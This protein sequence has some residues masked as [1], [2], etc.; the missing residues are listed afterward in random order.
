[1]ELKDLLTLMWRNVIYIVLGLILGAG[2]G[3]IVSKYQAP[4]YE[5][6]TK[7]FV[8]RTRQQSSSD[9]LSLSD[10]QLLAINIQMAKSQPVLNE[11][12]AQLGSKIDV[13]NIQV[14][15]IPNTLILQIKVQDSDA[16]R[17]ATIA[18]LL[19]NT[20]VQQNETLLSGRYLE[21][22]N[23]INQQLDQ[24]QKQ[25]DDL[26]VRIT[27]TKTTSVQEQLTLVKQQIEELKNESTSLETD[28]ANYPHQYPTPLQVVLLSEKQLRLQQVYSMLTL[29][30]QI[31]T[32]LTYTGKPG[33]DSSNLDNPQITVLQSALDTYK[34]INIALINN[35][36]SIRLAR[37]QSSQNVTQIVSAAPPK[38]PVRPMP[39]VYLL[40]GSGVGLALAA[41]TI[42]IIDQLDDSL[43]SAGQI[44]ELLGLPILG[45]VFDHR[46]NKDKLITAFGAGSK[47]VDAMRVLGTNLEIAGIKK[48]IRTLLI[49]NADQS[50]ARTNIAANLAI[51]NAQLGKQVILLDGDLK[52]PH[53]HTLFGMENQK[54][55]AELL[56]GKVDI[57]NACHE[58][59]NVEGMTLIPSG[60]VEKDATGWLTSEKLT[61]LMS[62]LKKNADLVIVDCPATESADAQIL[63]SRM[64]AVL[65]VVRM[66]HTHIE[67]AQAM[68]KR[69]QLIGARLTGAVIARTIQ[70]RFDIPLQIKPV[71]TEKPAQIKNEIETPAVSLPQNS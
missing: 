33:Q 58:V 11:V 9:M 32:N 12:A 51:V 56:N 10:D 2:L 65:L 54:G 57:R 48:N 34:Q 27:Q 36:E 26:Q 3:T 35:R 53:L 46:R 25:I 59:Q 45:S 17:A 4:V 55:F 8:S 62:A 23:G 41:I 39:L 7:I 70:Y 37:T 43:K 64:E 47:E 24:V 69:F 38:I 52:H 18:N 13:D 6:S 1:M 71:K 22:E 50:S 68:L 19:V 49:V 63:A 29:Y 16:Q 31:Q 5:A 67:A 66:G 14:E 61:Q 21:I 60:S 15:A 20:L 44:E 40:L 42:L 28:I 30:Q